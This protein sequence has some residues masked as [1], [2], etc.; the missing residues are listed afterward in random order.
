VLASPLFLGWMF[1]HTSNYHIGLIVF[2]F[3]YTS[4]SVFFSSAPG[5]FHQRGPRALFN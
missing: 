1:D 2:L 4:S 3:M 5:L